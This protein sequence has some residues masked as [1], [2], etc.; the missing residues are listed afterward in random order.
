MVV[1][2]V[3]VDGE[4]LAVLNTISPFISPITQFANSA[5]AG[6]TGPAVSTIQSTLTS[7][8]GI[9]S[10]LLGLILGGL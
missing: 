5:I 9:V 3:A 6:V 1:D 10:Q 8:S 7:I 2:Q 4:A